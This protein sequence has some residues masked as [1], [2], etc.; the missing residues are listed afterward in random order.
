MAVVNLGQ[1]L[2][3]VVQEVMTSSKP[4]TE[5]QRVPLTALAPYRDVVNYQHAENISQLQLD[6]HS[7]NTSGIVLAENDGKLVDY[8]ACLPPPLTAVRISLNRE[9]VKWTP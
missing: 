8:P 2:N 1:W 9:E 3:T 5:S 7:G 4:T 6:V